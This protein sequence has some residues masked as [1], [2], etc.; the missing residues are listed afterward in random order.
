M[1]KYLTLA[2][3]LSMLVF[4]IVSAQIYFGNI[5]I[6]ELQVVEKYPNN[7]TIVPNGSYGIIQFNAVYTPWGIAQERVRASV[8]DLEP[9]TYYQL[10][11]YGDNLH[12]DV[13]PY[14]TCIG[15]PRKTSSQGYFKGNSE[16]FNFINILGDTT[17]QKFWV[18][19]SKDVD[20]ELGRMI[21]WEP[22]SYLFE[23]RTI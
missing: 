16:Q 12:N 8:W 3:V 18:V 23:T 9:K 13:W 6:D 10:I 17:P 20:C 7:W 2:I 19:L 11:Y 5:V 14:A 15:E 4:P 1:K 21:S 22:K